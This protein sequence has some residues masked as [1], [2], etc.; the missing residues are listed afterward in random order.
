MKFPESQR[1][2]YDKNPL[3]EVICQLRFPKIL[4]I[5]TEAPVNF[6]EEIRSKYPTLNSPRP[7]EFP[8]LS[9]PQA[10]SSLILMNQ[11]LSYEFID[12]DGCWKLVLSSDFLALSTLRYE[13]WGDF[14]SRLFYATD[15]L[16]KHYSPTHFTRIGLRYQDFIV[17]S[18]LE[19]MNE[20]WRNLLQPAILGIFIDDNLP[21][22][23]FTEALS[24]FAC[25]LDYADAALRVRYGLARKEESEEL[26]Y[27]IDADFYTENITEISNA[28]D[29][30][31]RFNREA[32]NFFRWC[33]TAKLQQALQPQ[34]VS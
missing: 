8:V 22:Q 33:I 15:I 25:R 31:D 24:G 17:R 21:E 6:Q 7:V 14:K 28:T 20:P 10:G 11:G 12:K 26:G 13:N 27:L 3:A 18:E 4:R 2:S 16:V 30:L 9:S 5:E 32:G 29:S 34:S 1:V 19:L 23:D